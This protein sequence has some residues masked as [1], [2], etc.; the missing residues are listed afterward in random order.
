MRR[1]GA[2]GVRN[3]RAGRNEDELRHAVVEGD[4][5][6]V[7]LAIG[8]SETKRPHNGRIAALQ[9]AQDAALPAAV[10]F[11]RFG[12]DQNLIAL[13]GGVDLVGR[14]ENILGRRGSACVP[15]GGFS[16]RANE[17]VAVAVQ[18][19]T[20]GDE[21]VARCGSWAGSSLGKAPALAVKLHEPATRSEARQLLEEETA[22]AAT[23]ER[24]LA[25]QLL[26]CGLLAGGGGDPGEQFAI[27]HTP[28]LRQFQEPQ[29]TLESLPLRYLRRPE[30]SLKCFRTMDFPD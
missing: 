21:I 12:L 18:I 3:F 1:G 9:D 10:G 26:V 22:V 2:G 29:C 28:R 24:E 16:I 20:A 6:I 4:N 5:H 27:G 14:D 25:D 17:A 13:H 7:A 30:N 19:Q 8:T 23:G 11:G 15:C